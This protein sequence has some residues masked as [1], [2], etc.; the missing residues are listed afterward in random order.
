M[1][2]LVNQE[3]DFNFRFIKLFS[4]KEYHK[5]LF[6]FSIPGS[7]CG[8]TRQLCPHPVAV[9]LSEPGLGP[10][11]SLFVAYEGTHVTG[12]SLICGLISFEDF[13][14]NGNDKTE[15]TQ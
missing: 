4:Y 3:Q 9:A 8:G 6:H 5:T 10:D 11:V 2:F 12:S 7:R 13:I 14:R 1:Y 15:N